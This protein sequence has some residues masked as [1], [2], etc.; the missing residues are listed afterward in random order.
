ML[1]GSHVGYEC[2]FHLS[3]GP[4]APK[5]RSRACVFLFDWNMFY[6]LEQSTTHVELAL[7]V[8][9]S[10]GLVFMG[11]IGVL[12]ENIIAQAKHMFKQVH[13]SFAEA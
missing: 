13:G 2:H 6:M 3:R 5:F 12:N 9:S 8:R 10:V 11:I 1:G 7:F 4:L